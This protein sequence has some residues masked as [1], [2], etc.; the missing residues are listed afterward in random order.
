MGAC[1]PASDTRYAII[2][3]TNKGEIGSNVTLEGLHIGDVASWEVLDSNHILLELAITRKD[4]RIPRSATVKYRDNLLGE[5]WVDISSEKGRTPDVGNYTNRD[6][7]H[8]TYL[9]L[10]RID[11]AYI[12]RLIDTAG[13][14]KKSLDSVANGQ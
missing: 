14:I 2:E 10:P 5:K 7:L 13:K 11:T 9:P 6:T 12:R 1:R 8:G 3:H 4:I